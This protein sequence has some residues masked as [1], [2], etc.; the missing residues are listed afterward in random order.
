VPAAAPV[1]RAGGL[2]AVRRGNAIRVTWE[3]DRPMPAGRTFHVTGSTTR[4]RYA[5]PVVWGGGETEE[6]ER[7]F[8]VTLRPADGVRWVTLYSFGARPL[9]QVIR[10]R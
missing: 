6:R 4:S 3:T 10:V 8:T 9:K 2:R 1:P 5:E 7:S